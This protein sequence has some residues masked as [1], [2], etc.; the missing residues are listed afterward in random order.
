[1]FK[2][3]LILALLG[4]LGYVGYLV[5]NNLSPKEQ[6]VVARKAGDVVDDAKDLAG[7]A[8][9]SLTGVAKDGIKKI[10]Q[11][12]SAAP[13]QRDPKPDPQPAEKK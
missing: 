7:K 6:A 11:E 2:K 10:E 8:A 5:W 13:G 1:M 3:I 9:D 4:G 12:D